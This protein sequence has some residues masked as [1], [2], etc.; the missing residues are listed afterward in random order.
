MVRSVHVAA[1]ALG[2][3]LLGCAAKTTSPT[4]LTGSA[5]L[6]TFPTKP[7][8]VRVTDEA[9]RSVVAPIG[10]DGLFTVA[11]A[12]GHR[13]SV[14]FV[15]TYGGVGLAFP[16]KTG[17]LD[18]SFVVGSDGARIG[19]GSVHFASGAPT[20]GFRIMSTSSAPSVADDQI[21]QC[22]DGSEGAD[23]SE[24]QDDSPQVDSASNMAVAEHNAPIR[25][26]GCEG[27]DAEQDDE[28]QQGEH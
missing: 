9:G 4:T 15:T 13:Y 24:A 14:T 3:G 1:V 16:R 27:D 8:Q 28:E 6:S 18:S 22:E 19:L 23:S 12:R 7:E 5:T 20:G 17:R 25:V 26:D 11:L 10:A 2:L 21:A